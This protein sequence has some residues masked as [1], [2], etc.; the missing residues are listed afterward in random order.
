MRDSLGAM[1]AEMQLRESAHG[2]WGIPVL[3]E[4]RCSK[5]NRAKL[6]GALG[7]AWQSH[8]ARSCSHLRGARLGASS[9]AKVALCN[10]SQTQHCLRDIVRN[11]SPLRAAKRQS[12][13]SC[14]ACV[15]ETQG[16]SVI[17]G[18]L[19]YFV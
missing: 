9:K 10:L 2:L 12:E 18:N 5:F 8:D 3:R 16:E 11:F 4:E 13:K 15:E 14:Y 19:D 6:A 1:Q 7:W 17:S